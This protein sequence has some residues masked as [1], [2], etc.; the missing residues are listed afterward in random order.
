ESAETILRMYQHLFTRSLGSAEQ[1]E[2][3]RKDF[4]EEKS[5]LQA[6][7]RSQIAI[8]SEREALGAQVAA[9]AVRAATQRAAVQRGI[10]ALDQELTEYESRRTFVVTAP[11]DGTATA[12]LANA[13]Q[14]AVPAQPLV[15]LLALPVAARS[16]L[17]HQGRD[18]DMS[19]RLTFSGRRRTPVVLQ[20]EAA[21]CGL[22]CLAM[23]AGHYGHRTDL[24]TLRG[25]H[26]MSLKGTTLAGLIKIAAALNLSSR[27]LR[28]ELEALGRLRLP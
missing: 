8:T 21:E 1:S 2:A 27:P 3:K 11:L 19:Y 10:S 5:R 23:V 16:A 6:L 9:A 13:G 7:Q 22:A 26:S 14:T 17:Q 4:L 15:S 25:R 20:T 12:V 28:L 18:L 24:A